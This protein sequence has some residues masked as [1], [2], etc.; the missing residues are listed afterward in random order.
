MSF[1]L[2]SISEIVVKSSNSPSS[3]PLKSSTLI[4]I[5]HSRLRGSYTAIK[6]NR[7]VD[8]D[9]IDLGIDKLALKR[10]FTIIY[11]PLENI[12]LIL[13]DS[14]SRLINCGLK[15]GPVSLNAFDIDWF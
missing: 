7:R 6:L 13:Q 3:F 15:A 9:S 12:Y 5:E 8:A 11:I 1:Y 4:F 10:L 2:P 14:F